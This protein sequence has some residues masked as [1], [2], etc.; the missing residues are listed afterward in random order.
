MQFHRAARIH[1]ALVAT[2]FASHS[3]IAQAA[4]DSIGPPQGAWGAEASYG[5][6]T[7]VS[8]LRFS[9]PRTAW[10]LGAFVYLG[11]EA[12]DQSTQTGIT[13]STNTTASLNVRVGRRWWTGEP[14]ERMR[15]FVGLGVAGGFSK[16]GNTRT[17]E[18]SAIGELG[19]T[20]FFGPHVS[21]GTAGELSVAR[22]HDRYV[23][24]IGPALATDRWYLRGNLARFNA[25][26]YF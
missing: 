3:A 9:S 18:G 11:Q 7:G 15:P 17:L 20:Y 12:S 4:R 8:L 26:V 22:G 16:F 5:P 1:L 6:S 25:A 10:L 2:L 19:A 14:N 13:R 21:L 24:A 23:S